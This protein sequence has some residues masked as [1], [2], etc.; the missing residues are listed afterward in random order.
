MESA[1]KMSSVPV[2]HAP[3][4]AIGVSKL[5]ERRWAK[6]STQPSAKS[7]GKS[8]G[9][10]CASAKSRLLAATAA[11]GDS[12]LVRDGRRKPRKTVS[13]STGAS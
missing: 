12:H 8:R 10:K 3:C 13:S 11:G 4:T 1:V 7:C 2:F 9:A 5:R 6:P